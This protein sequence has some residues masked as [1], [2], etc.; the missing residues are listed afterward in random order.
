MANRFTPAEWG[1]SY[2][3][4]I[5]MSSVNFPNRPTNAES[6]AMKDFIH[7]V[8]MLLPCPSCSQHAK[9]FIYNS[10]IDLAVESGDNLF[11][12]WVHFHNKV[13]QRLNKPTVSV[14]KARKMYNSK[15]NWGPTFWFVF[16]LSSTLYQTS[17]SYYMKKF[18]ESLPIILPTYSSQYNSITFLENYNLSVAV[19]SRRKLFDFWYNFHNYINRLLRKKEVSYASVKELYGLE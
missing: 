12:Y 17:H 2:W 18:L 14:Q 10:N 4:M 6:N 13:N 15:Q 7:V 9:E 3:Y 8:P 19:E 1:P 5:H 16:H 11:H